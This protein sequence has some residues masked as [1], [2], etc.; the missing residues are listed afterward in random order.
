MTAAT[1]EVNITEWMPIVAGNKYNDKMG[2]FTGA[3]KTSNG[4]KIK[5]LNVDKIL[6]VVGLHSADGKAQDFTIDDDTLTLT[7]GTETTT[8]SGVIRYRQ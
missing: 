5:V 4:D 1:V 3:T 7:S 6:Q 8:I 2:Y